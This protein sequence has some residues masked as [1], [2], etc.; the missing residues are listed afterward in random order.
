VEKD[1]FL[2][3]RLKKGDEE[4]YSKLV[5]LYGKKMYVYAVSLS[6]DYSLAKD[7]VQEV[8]ISTYENRKK[9]DSQYSLSGFLYR[10]VYNNFINTYHKNK[11]INK[12]KESYII[13][14]NQV[15]TE[16]DDPKDF[17]QKLSFVKKSIEK[18]PK[19]CREIFILSKKDGYTNQEISEILN[20]SIKTV[21]T[22]I[23]IAF[24]KI[25]DDLE[26]KNN[27]N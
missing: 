26:T 25:R 22:Q 21:E 19:K 3:E 13:T 24:S 4:A 9:L 18:L 12:L 27:R 15:M 23:S 14:L 10:S 17:E 1:K 8:F 20:I 16:I 2:F 6:G 5:E 11:S 7:I